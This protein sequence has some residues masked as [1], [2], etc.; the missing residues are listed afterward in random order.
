MSGHSNIL[1]SLGEAAAGNGLLTNLEAY[2]TMDDADISGSTLIDV[3]GTYDGTITGATTGVSGVVGEAFSF[4]GSGDYV[5]MGNVLNFDRTDAFSYALWM[6]KDSDGNLEFPISKVKHAVPFNG[7][8]LQ[9]TTTDKPEFFLIN[10]NPSNLIRVTATTATIKAADGWVHYVATYDGSSSASGVTQY[11]NGSAIASTIVNNSLSSSTI[12]TW[13]LMIG[14]RPN[15]T[16]YDFD[17]DL[18]EIGIWSRELSSTDV[19]ALYNGGSGL[20]YS[21]FTS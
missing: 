15:L 2:W 6:K 11:I 17:G 5:N 13:D 9:L 8:E 16:G 12:F 19:A 4:D 1:L 21:S 14:R 7:W 3:H 20:A 18:D 10:N